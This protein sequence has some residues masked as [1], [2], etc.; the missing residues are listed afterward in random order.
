M[1]APRECNDPLTRDGFG[2]LGDGMLREFT[3]QDQSDSRLYLTRRDSRLL[4]VCG[5]L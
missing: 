5:K 1:W 3:R 4:G 2:T